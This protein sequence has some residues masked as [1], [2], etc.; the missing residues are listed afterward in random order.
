M[1]EEKK[2]QLKLDLGCGANKR[3]GFVGVDKY[4]TPCVDILHDLLVYPWPFEDGSVGEVYCSHFFEHIPGLDRPRWMEELYRVLVP[5]AKATVITPYYKSPRAT[6]DFTHQWP[7]VSE[8]SYLYFN[9]AWRE[10]NGLTHGLYD[11][12][13]DFDYTYG[14]ALDTAW[15]TR[16]EEARNFAIRYYWCTIADLHVALIKR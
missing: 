2:E 6:Q 11:V 10:R 12:K 3:A 13:A 9:K 5:G 16:D 1:T 14:Y 4:Q 15:A 8:E 7:P